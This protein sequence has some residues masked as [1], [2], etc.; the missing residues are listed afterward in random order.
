MRA[1]APQSL[2]H[3]PL[4]SV[5]HNLPPAK[6]KAL[7]TFALGV[8]VLCSSACATL[9]Q[10]TSTDVQVNLNDPGPAGAAPLNI[11]SASAIELEKLPGVGKVVAERI[12][13]YRLENGPFRRPEHLMMVR[14]ISESK[15]RAMQSM[16]TV[17][18]GAQAE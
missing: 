13:S 5:K 17:E 8:L 2:Y 14:G 11:N 1:A 12:V 10:K 18:S 3:H 7:L 16:I 15:F 9:P 6:A 4:A